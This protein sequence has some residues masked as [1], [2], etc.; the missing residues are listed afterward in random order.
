MKNSKIFCKTENVFK[1]F[2]FKFISLRFLIDNQV[3]IKN[4]EKI[5]LILKLSTNINDIKIQNH[6]L[7]LKN[8]Y[9]FGSILKFF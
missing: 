1:T 6:N 8:F 4:I 5:Y 9:I 3:L 7:Y 2:L